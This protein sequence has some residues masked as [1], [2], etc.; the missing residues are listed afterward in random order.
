MRPGLTASAVPN[1]TAARCSPGSPRPD[2]RAPQSPCPVASLPRTEHITPSWLTPPLADAVGGKH[3]GETFGATARARRS[4]GESGEHLADH[5]W[6]THGKDEPPGRRAATRRRRLGEEHAKSNTRG[7]K[8]RER[9]RH[10]YPH[11][12]RSNSGEAGAA[13]KLAPPLAPLAAV[14][15][16]SARA[17]HEPGCHRSAMDRRLPNPPASASCTNR[18]PSRQAARQVSTTSSARRDAVKLAADSRLVPGG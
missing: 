7:M 3:C 4:E 12:F 17:E 16:S 2:A 6:L 18:R 15:P 1:A 13:I 8:G 5:R 10:Q 14:V 11:S 9:R